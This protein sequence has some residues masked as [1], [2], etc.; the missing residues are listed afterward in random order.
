MTSILITGEDKKG[1][2]ALALLAKKMGVRVHHFTS[3]QTEDFLLGVM[4][5]KTKSKKSVSK[6]SVMRSLKAV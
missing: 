2:E 5:D 6:R 4:M 3:E 1:V